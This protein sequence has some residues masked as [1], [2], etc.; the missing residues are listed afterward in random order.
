MKKILAFILAVL[1]V[2]AL[3]GCKKKEPACLSHEQLDEL[4]TEISKAEFI[5]GGDYGGEPLRLL[6][7]Y[8]KIEEKQISRLFSY[9]DV[10]GLKEFSETYGKYDGKK[11]A[12][13]KTLKIVEEGIIDK[14]FE[15]REKKIG[16]ALELQKA[17]DEGNNERFYYLK[18]CIA[19]EYNQYLKN[20]TQEQFNEIYQR[21][22]SKDKNGIKLED[23]TAE[24][25]VILGSYYQMRNVNGYVMEDYNAN[26]EEADKILEELKYINYCNKPFGSHGSRAT[27][28]K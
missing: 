22:E 3:V 7:K 23:C 11:R 2:G 20:Y 16:Y 4:F 19:A 18:Y 12:D 5:V 6:R 9:Y 10:K 28:G 24:E 26:K 21:F 15:A 1:T 17:Y 14:T 25:V 13:A 27:L 8:G